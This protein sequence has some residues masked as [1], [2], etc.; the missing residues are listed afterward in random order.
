MS[1]CVHQYLKSHFKEVNKTVVFLLAVE[2]LGK[3]LCA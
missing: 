3:M 1:V 2:A